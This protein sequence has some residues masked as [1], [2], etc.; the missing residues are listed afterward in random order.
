MHWL[1]V[2]LRV[3][4]KLATLMFK[5]LHGLAPSY[6]SDLCQ[7]VPVISCRLRSSL[8][9]QLCC[10]VGDK[11][12]TVADPRVWNMLPALMR[13]VHIYVR[14]RPLLKAHCLSQAAAH[15]HCFRHCIGIFYTYL[16]YVHDDMFSA[17]SGVR[18]IFGISPI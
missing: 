14:F 18:L 10:A 11:S 4:L 2:R 6:L 8:H 3:Q 13:L 5:T 9:V 1:S 7:R 15:S 16:L 12:F 17:L